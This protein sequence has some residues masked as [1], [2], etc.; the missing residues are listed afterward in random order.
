MRG[1]RLAH[2]KIHGQY[3][4]GEIHSRSAVKFRHHSCPLGEIVAADNSIKPLAA[5]NAA[6][7]RTE[8]RV[9]MKAAESFRT[10]K[11]NL[12]TCSV[13]GQSATDRRS[14]DIEDGAW[15]HRY[16]NAARFFVEKSPL[17]GR[18]RS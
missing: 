16:I 1:Q 14:Q 13:F 15:K 9:G 3:L 18:F 8:L 7:D 10:L 2:A 5:T 11:R 17:Q 4:A 6:A 12:K